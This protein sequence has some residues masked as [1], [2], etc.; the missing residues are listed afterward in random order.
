MKTNLQAMPKKD[1]WL[2]MLSGLLIG[3]LFMPVLAVAKPDLYI[4]LRM[5]ILPFFLI[6]TPLGLAIA[7]IISKKIPVIW[8]IAKFGVTGVLNVLV[9]FGVLTILTISLEKYF[10]IN[11][12]DILLG[13]GVL[14]VSAYSIYKA[15]SFTIANINSYF[16]NKYWTFDENSQ[17]KKSEFAQF[18]VVSIVG[19]IINVAVASFVFNY[20]HPFTGMGSEQWGL[21]GAAA[22]S[23][24]G[25]FWNFLGYKFLVFKK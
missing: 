12:T 6:G 24:L 2:G 22:G 11:S 4:Q 1:F 20:I 23:I 17:K 15:L 25:L 5:A 19:F 13:F 14:I 7:H 3:L 10:D 18:F 8:Q 21:I 9:D 16:W